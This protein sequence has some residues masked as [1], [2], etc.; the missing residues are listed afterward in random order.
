MRSRLVAPA[1]G[2]GGQSRSTSSFSPSCGTF[3]NLFTISM[4][5]TSPLKVCFW[6]R[7]T[8]EPGRD[9]SRRARLDPARVE[10]TCCNRS[11]TNSAR[12]SLS[13][14]PTMSL[15]PPSARPTTP[16]PAI[17]LSNLF[18]SPTPP[19]PANA[20]RAANPLF[21]DASP[22]ASP[23]S[24]R[25]SLPPDGDALEQAMG[26]FD[27]L[28]DDDQADAGSGAAPPGRAG[29]GRGPGETSDGEGGDGAIKPVP[30]RVIAKIDA[31]RSVP[32]L[33]R[34]VGGFLLEG[35]SR[36]GGRVNSRTSSRWSL[37]RC[38]LA[39]QP[40]DCAGCWVRMGFLVWSRTRKRSSSRARGTRS[41]CL[42]PTSRRR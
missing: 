21:Y 25:G 34:A 13:A 39:R 31:A 26:L 5:L 16:P 42:L 2:V 38:D 7:V 11:S 4:N 9:A 33:A 29:G 18:D 32:E 17:D 19:R 12:Q 15:S 1:W 41:V 23:T 28:S 37:T 10:L 24:R 8:V 40:H 30:K 27:N 36:G 14:S 6:T 22:S 3:G 35:R 20:T